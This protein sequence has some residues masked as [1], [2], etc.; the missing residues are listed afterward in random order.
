[1]F[2]GDAERASCYDDCETAVK[3]RNS[4]LKFNKRGIVTNWVPKDSRRRRGRSRLSRYI[5]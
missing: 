2:I 1:M 4:F 3:V 5:S